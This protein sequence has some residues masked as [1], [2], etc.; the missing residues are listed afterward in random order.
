MLHTVSTR[1]VTTLAVAA[2]AFVGTAATALAVAPT[3]PQPTEMLADPPPASNPTIARANQIMGLDYRAFDALPKNEQ[4][5]DWSNDGCSTPWSPGTP[6][7]GDFNDDFFRACIQH[8]FGY[9][10]YGVGGLAL[11]PNENTRG[12]IDDRLLEE[13]RRICNNEV[14]FIDRPIR[15]V[16]ATTFHTGVRNFGHSAFYS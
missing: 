14:S 1:I 13:M 16:F 6:I 4:P 11:S 15:H 12:W 9:A 7:L 8:D 10:N 2:M 3:S 5:F